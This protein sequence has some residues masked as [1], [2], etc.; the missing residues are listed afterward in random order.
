MNLLLEPFTKLQ[1]VNDLPLGPGAT[2]AKSSARA[3]H[4]RNLMANILMR[5][6]LN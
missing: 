1:Q 4:P 3:L 5:L 6:I 2:L